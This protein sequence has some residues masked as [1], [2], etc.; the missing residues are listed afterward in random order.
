MSKTLYEITDDVRALD[1]L[2]DDLAGDVSDD[3]VEAAIDAWFKENERNI[4]QK[5]DGYG[6][7][8]K[9]REYLAEAR[10]AE[11]KRLLD[12]GSTDMNLIKRLKERIRDFLIANPDSK[13][14]PKRE[15]ERFK[16]W[17]QKNGQRSMYM[18]PR[19]TVD[20]LSSHYIKTIQVIDQDALRRDAE[21]L[22]ELQSKFT[23]TA[24]EES[25][26]KILAKLLNGV[27]W[28]QPVGYH[29]RIR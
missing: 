6:V 13:K 18:D 4:D 22:D 24:K 29:L 12:L 27:A 14:G 28:M 19:L 10:K 8:I 23:L 5:L 15:T 16:F 3:Q 11:A 20:D 9:N 25:E 26:L 21:R 17:V 1:A 7:V 2:L